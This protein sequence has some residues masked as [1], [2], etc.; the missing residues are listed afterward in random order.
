MTIEKTLVPLS[1]LRL[2]LVAMLLGSMLRGVLPATA[3]PV[4]GG[5]APNAPAF[6]SA[7]DAHTPPSCDGARDLVVDGGKTTITGTRTFD[8]VCVVDGGVLRASGTLRAGLL[9]VDAAS[10][11][12]AD[13]VPG[14]G[15]PD[16]CGDQSSTEPDG[17]AGSSLHILAR[18][19]VVQGSMSADGG[20]GLDAVA[21]DTP[22]Y[23]GGRG[24]HGGRLTLD[25]ARLLLTA[26]LSA[27]GGDGGL[28]YY[29]DGTPGH[30]AEPD[31]D[32][33]GGNGG[34]GGEVV[35]RTGQPLSPRAGALLD[36]SG[37]KGGEA[38]VKGRYPD[39][40]HGRAGRT[41]VATLTMTQEAALPRPP[42]PLVMTFGASPA[43]LPA[44]PDDTFARGMRCG[45]GDLRVAAYQE[46]SLAGLHRYPHVCVYKGGIIRA[47]PRLILQAQTILIQ[48][49][50][51]L[52]TYAAV[53][54][55]HGRPQSGRY[56]S[57]GSCVANAAAP[58]A[59][60]AGA[61][62][63]VPASGD[64]LAD[65]MVTTPGGDGGGT[66]TLRGTRIL[67]SGTMSVDGGNGSVGRDAVAWVH[68][69]FGPWSG[70]DGG[71][72]GGI[73]VVADELQMRGSVSATGGVGGHGGPYVARGRRA[74]PNTLDADTG[75]SAESGRHGGPGCIKLLVGTLRVPAV[76]LPV[77][78]PTLIGRP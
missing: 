34:D 27:A 61:S 68:G 51:S 10:R 2:T 9:Y 41:S 69:Y 23:S 63:G 19:A 3:R 22:I 72:G 76:D 42:S 62:T 74:T 33:P 48:D 17:A 39:G 43:Q 11:I 24:G 57:A 46:I 40:K 18:E 52:L 71:S 8:R 4:A 21:C 13:G 49:G 5:G 29:S 54:L 45:K 65:G 20:G 53:G 30:S 75:Y 32:S 58:H 67:L 77:S 14:G 35:V 31:I 47:A 50:A 56:E 15:M 6:R 25:I 36:V 60:V 64:P 70:S 7:A 38:G 12:S 59:G 28:G 1:P 55:M 66:I 78:G 37:G 26:P 73:L 16:E 44:Q